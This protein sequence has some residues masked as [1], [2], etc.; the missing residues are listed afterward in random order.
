MQ[1]FFVFN[2][3]LLVIFLILIFAFNNNNESNRTMQVIREETC[4]FV[5]M[6]AIFV[7]FNDFFI[8]LK[9]YL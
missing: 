9:S 4:E 1:L 5:N 7:H 3:I 6:I 8:H 2:L